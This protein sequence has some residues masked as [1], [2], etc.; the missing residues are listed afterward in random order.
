MIF[1]KLLTLLK[2]L[3]SF[4]NRSKTLQPDWAQT[5]LK[6]STNY[7]SSTPVWAFSAHFWFSWFF[8][9]Q[10]PKK[11]IFW[12]IFEPW[13]SPKRPRNYKITQFSVQNCCFV[14]SNYQSIVRKLLKPSEIDFS[15][16]CV[17][18]RFRALFTPV[19]T[20]WTG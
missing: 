15:E 3:K 2:V 12:P 14:F 16:K 19:G 4:L 8:S 11:S 9:T 13:K 1:K 17:F 7:V 6:W 10:N 20:L 18:G 5:S